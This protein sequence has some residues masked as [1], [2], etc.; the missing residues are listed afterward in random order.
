[1]HNLLRYFRQNRKKIIKVAL[2]VAFLIAILQL[3]NYLAGRNN[4]IKFE[5]SNNNNL[6][7]ESNGT[8]TSDKSAISGAKISTNEIKNVGNKI[9]EFVDL[10]NNHKLDEAYNMLSN[11][12]K[13]ILY[14]DLQNF[15]Q[16]YYEPLFKE[17]NK[18]YTIQ[19]WSGNT[20]LVKFIEDL[21]AT[22]KSAKESGYTD[23]ITIVEENG[24]KKLNINSFIKKEEIS[25]EK[26]DNNIKIKV[27]NRIKYM[28][29]EEYE[30]EVTNNT[31]GTILLDQL[32][33]SEGIYLKD[34]KENRHY[35]Y[36]NELTKDEMKVFSKYTKK[37]KIKFD[38]PYITGRRIN[39]LCFSMIVL[40]YSEKNY[41]AIDST[42]ISVNI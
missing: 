42:K 38:N 2:I 25:K 4:N 13:E 37:I 5:S 33:T 23:Y 10:C 17:E 12:C 3:L 14:P 20:Y 35:A 34:S 15:I 36:A 28:E 31:N 7:K 27:L 40:D 30:L 26:E 21:L 6:I 24:E 18:T 16:N 32:T 39:N 22:G 8:I 11:S 1:M 41:A 9:N 29:Y 19:N